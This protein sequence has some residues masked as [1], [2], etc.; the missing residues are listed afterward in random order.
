[1]N[2]GNAVIE[3]AEELVAREAEA[4]V[5]RIRARLRLVCDAG[6]GPLVCG[7]GEEISQARRLAAPN[8]DKCIDC[9]TFAERA[10]AGRRR[11]R[12]A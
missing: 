6:D 5:A 12:K 7:C 10:G 1:M 3:A 9:A 4:G 11:Q 2:F 8:T